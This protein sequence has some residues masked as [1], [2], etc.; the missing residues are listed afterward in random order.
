MK[1]SVEL[2]IDELVLHGLPPAQRE[3]IAAAVQAELQRLLDEGGLPPA[4]AQGGR[5]PE[6]RLGDLRV[7]PG[8]QPAALGAQIAASIYTSMGGEGVSSPQT[9]R[10][11]A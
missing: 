6:L 8:A 11:K 9:G 4:L 2:A 3:R 1:A 10:S 7:A 5:L